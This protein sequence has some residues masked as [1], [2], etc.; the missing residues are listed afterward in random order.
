[1]AKGP[2]KAKKL[3]GQSNMTSNQSLQTVLNDLNKGH[4]LEPLQNLARKFSQ[5]PSE[6]SFEVDLLNMLLQL[7]TDHQADPSLPIHT[8]AAIRFSSMSS[9]CYRFFHNGR[10]LNPL[11]D[12]EPE[13]KKSQLSQ[14]QYAFPAPDILR[15][16]SRE[17]LT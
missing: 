17:N 9:F 15:R 7:R 16:W 11:Q 3:K 6:D 1:M 4:W 12:P 2:I 13:F 14:S 5:L 10:P 8:L